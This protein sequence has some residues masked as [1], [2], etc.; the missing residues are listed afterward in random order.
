MQ[1]KTHAKSVHALKVFEKN[2][3]G[4]YAFLGVAKI[5]RSVSLWMKERVVMLVGQKKKLVSASFAKLQFWT[6]IK[7]V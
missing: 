6:E 3:T 1:T 4:T 5:S 2:A 7:R